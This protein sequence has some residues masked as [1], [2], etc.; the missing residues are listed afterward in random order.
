M[1]KTFIHLT[2]HWYGEANLKS[3]NDDLFD[4]ITLSIS[5]GRHRRC[6]IVFEYKGCT[7]MSPRL[8]LYSDSWWALPHI[9]GVLKR[10]ATLPSDVVGPTNLK[11]I[12]VEEGFTD[13][14]SATKPE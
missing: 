6:D 4:D 13:E 7:G 5:E 14:T 2:Q 11:Q 3:R 9:K 10:L 12:L 8:C 1:K